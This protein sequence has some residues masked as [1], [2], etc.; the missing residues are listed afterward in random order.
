MLVITLGHVF[1]IF[2]F[3]LWVATGTFNLIFIYIDDIHIICFNDL[4]LLSPITAL[5]AFVIFLNNFNCQGL[6]QGGQG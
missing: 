3:Y 5:F 6:G 2:C 4:N 1:V